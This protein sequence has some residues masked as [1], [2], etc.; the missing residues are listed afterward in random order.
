MPTKIIILAAGHGTRMCSDKPKVLANIAGKPMLQHILATCSRLNIAEQIVVGGYQFE[1]LKKAIDPFFKVTW[2]YQ[3]RQLGTAHAVGL[4]VEHISNEDIAI[5]LVGDVPLISEETLKR[6]AVL[7]SSQ[8]MG[9]VTQH[10]ADPSGLGRIKRDQHGDI[11]G[12]VEHKD[13]SADELEITEINTGI[14]AI[15][16]AFLKEAL[17]KIDNKNT[18]KEYYLTDI[19][20]I[21][22]SQG[23]KIAAIQPA[24]NFEV[25]GVNSRQQLAELEREYQLFQAY[26]YMKQ[27][28]S[29]ADPA[30]VDFRGSCEFGKD[31]E[32]DI[33]VIFEGDN[34][35]GE[36]CKIGANSILKNTKLGA[37]VIIEPM[38]I[39]EDV[40][41]QKNANIG[42]YARL[43]PGTEIGEGAKVGNF[44]E[45]KKSKLGAGSKASHL[46]YIGDAD[47]GENVN[48]GAGTITCNYDGVNKFK[49]EI[50]DGA[51]IGSNT[52]LVAPVK[53]GKNSTIGAG[54][55]IV[56]DASANKLTLA[57]ARQLVVEKWKR[58]KKIK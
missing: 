3:E 28:V 15:S 32:V 25:K 17:P 50:E 47:I 42:P 34:V 11:F 37:N 57:R 10:L 45:I 1:T 20:E 12:I 23:L 22:K 16:G 26:E 5:I 48:I 58:P 18:Q 33:N 27:G 30:R 49:T 44:V 40:H 54:S 36:N 38:S 31:V 9:I 21:A 4:A 29:F 51:F 41:V 39:L 6:L 19:I 55:T 56:N 8:Q 52:S 7:C 46:S 14:M 35:I 43:R 53:I 24:H 13:A 2:Q